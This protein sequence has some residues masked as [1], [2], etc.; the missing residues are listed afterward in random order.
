MTLQQ[1]SSSH[2]S[3]FVSLIPSS[4]ILICPPPPKVC[5]ILKQPECYKTSVLSWGFSCELALGWT[6]GKEKRL[7]LL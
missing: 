3:F 6:W 1:V 2:L 7:K 5:S 4:S